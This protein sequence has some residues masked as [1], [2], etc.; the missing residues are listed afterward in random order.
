M[1]LAP[2]EKVYQSEVVKKRQQCFDYGKLVYRL[3]VK[4]INHFVDKSYRQDLCKHLKR[5]VLQQ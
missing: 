3:L 4:C 1:M 5:R 2:N